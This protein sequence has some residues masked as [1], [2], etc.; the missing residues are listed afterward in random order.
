MA[1]FMCGDSRTHGRFLLHHL[2]VR[3]PGSY[4]MCLRFSLFTMNVWL[5]GMPVSWGW[6]WELLEL[7]FRTI[8]FYVFHITIIKLT[9]TQIHEYFNTVFIQEIVQLAPYLSF[10]ISGWISDL[11]PWD[12]SQFQPVKSHTFLDTSLVILQ[13]TNLAHYVWDLW[14]KLLQDDSFSF[15]LRVVPFL[16]MKL[17][18]CMQ[19]K[20]DVIEIQG[21]KSHYWLE[22]T[23]VT[24]L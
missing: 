22:L 3:N 17:V 6:R 18:L 14:A 7:I 10:S 16:C 12:V 21:R 1:V 2:I 11:P 20:Q 24:C 4:W 5:T 15:I 13:A 19:H 9:W 23:R 8:G